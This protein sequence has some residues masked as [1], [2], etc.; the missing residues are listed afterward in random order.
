MR[1][2]L[3]RERAA[4]VARLATS[5]PQF[6][7]GNFAGKDYIQAMSRAFVKDSDEV[8]TPPERPVSP[9]ANYVTEHGLALIEAELA[10]LHAA[11]AKAQADADRSALALTAR[12]LRYWQQRRASAE[13]IAAT[14][15]SDV[16]HFGSTVTIERGDGVRQS[17]RIVGEDE[18]DP[19]MGRC[20]MCRRWRM[21][22]SAGKSATWC[23]GPSPACLGREVMAPAC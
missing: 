23:G 6:P 16:V 2:L 22:S 15:N 7:I 20:L 3:Q 1:G 9:H 17:W 12:D 11:Y 21:H 10:R 4:F 18:A 14:P 5:P 13:L 8:E 19:R